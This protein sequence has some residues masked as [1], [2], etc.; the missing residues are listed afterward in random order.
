MVERINLYW[1]LD[2]SG[3]MGDVPPGSTF[4]KYVNA[5]GAIANVMRKIGHRVSVGATVF[6]TAFSPDPGCAPGSEIFETQ[7]GDPASF[8]LSGKEGPVLT[9]LLNILGGIPVSGGTPIAG[10]IV[11]VTPTITALEGTTA[12][13]LA[14][15]GAP[16]CNPDA[17]CDASQCLVNIEGLCQMAVNC[18]DP[19]LFLNGPSQCLDADPTKSAVQA[20]ADA[21]VPTYVVGMPGSELYA[22]FLEELAMAGTTARPTS[23]KYYAATAD[24]LTET[25]EQIGADIAFQCRVEL[26]EQPPDA[27]LVNV[28]FDSDL[29][30][31]DDIDGWAWI[32]PMT[33]ELR[34]QACADLKSGRYAQVQVAAGCPTFVP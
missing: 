4:N 28:Y 11:G 17:S 29:I 24:D 19:A 27:S 6:P 12:V 7:P 23:P 10:T 2:R 18:C 8:G 22:S 32:G 3:S 16:N 33:I 15:D 20:L 5:R 21:G 30:P 26:E 31:Q 14:T 13:I 9:S 1:I 25:L 34:G